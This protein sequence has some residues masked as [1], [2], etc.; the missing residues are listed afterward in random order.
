MR[1]GWLALVGAAALVGC[2]AKQVV[3]A[4]RAAAQRAGGAGG[5]ALAEVGELIFFD[6]NLSEPP[7]Q[8]CASCHSADTGFTGPTSDVN[9]RG[10]V[11]AGAADAPGDPRFG[12]RKPSSAAYATPSPVLHY[13]AEEGLFVG[14]LFWD[15]R[16]TGWKLGSAAAEQAQGPFLNPVEQNLPSAREVV[17]RICGG[18]YAAQ[19]TALFPEACSAETEDEIAAAYDQVGLAVA[20]FESSPAVNRYSSKYD[21]YLR[22]ET[23]LTPLEREG[24][25]L[26]KG[27]AKCA[28][29]HPADPGDHGEP[30]VFTDHTFDN[31]GLPRN[32]E[33]PFYDAPA[34]NNPDGGAYSDPG[35]GGFLASSRGEL[36]TRSAENLGK[37]RVPTLRNVDKRP[38]PGFV[39]A[40][41]HNGVFKTLE[42]I[43]RFYNTR[44]VLPRC[45]EVENP[46]FGASCWPPPEV[47]DNV[48]TE[49]L[50]DLGLT[51]REVNAIV[52]F[53]RTLSDE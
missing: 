13:D 3:P 48:N 40:Y 9:A 49:E 4:G 42:Q 7:G 19:F 46:A 27:K 2:G 28:E 41:G 53:M 23:E 26:F 16:A 38:S 35:L 32:P 43:V 24:L 6:P 47:A 5:G 34:W 18:P 17:A 12:N 51:D 14:G 39:K 22:G 50:G 10:A 21:R 31:L 25:A 29:C 45:E 33:N 11:Y 15:G 36:A 8:S 52:A 30:P 1:R 44:D 37:H 20:A